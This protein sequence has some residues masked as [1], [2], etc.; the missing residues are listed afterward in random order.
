MFQM[1]AD[2]KAKGQA[3][4]QNVVVNVGG[5]SNWPPPG[6]SNSH[7]LRSGL[8]RRHGSGAQAAATS[9]SNARPKALA[10]LTVLKRQ[11]FVRCGGPR[12][13]PNQGSTG[14]TSAFRIDR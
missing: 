7:L 9:E 5:D 1:I 3:D 14:S 11:S 12:R 6:D 2:L 10:G 13:Q 8:V 4:P